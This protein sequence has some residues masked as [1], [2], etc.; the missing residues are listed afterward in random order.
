MRSGSHW[1]A[2]LALVAA[3]PM[4]TSA[5]AA[6]TTI[7]FDTDAAG[8]PLSAP[9]A[10]TGTAPLTELYAPLGVHFSGPAPM[11]GGAI[12]HECGNFGL[13]PRSGSNVL[14]FNRGTSGGITYAFDPEHIRFDVPQ[15]TVTIFGG[16]RD[17]VS[18]L[19]IGYRGNI[20]LDTAFTTPTR[21][22]WNELSV[23][24][25]QGLDRVFLYA[26]VYS[27]TG[28]ESFVY[29]DLTFI[30]LLPQ[31][32]DDCRKGGWRDFPQF[33]NQG[34]CVSFAATRGKNQPAG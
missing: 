26:T 19:M 11:L 21:G 22:V 2:L 14:A 4:G 13:V 28:H 30:S 5:Y 33:T 20:E 17:D 10:F 8:A 12:T 18:F 15:R 7:S 9:C 16:G 24:A 32:R 3:F 23:S 34:D 29:D 25:A 6:E 31:S 1:I 27:N